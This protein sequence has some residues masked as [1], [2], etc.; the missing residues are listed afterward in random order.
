MPAAKKLSE[1]QANERLGTHQAALFDIGER[2]VAIGGRLAHTEQIKIGAI[3][4]VDGR[5]AAAPRRAPPL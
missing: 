4:N 2:V 5:H 1:E 3:Q